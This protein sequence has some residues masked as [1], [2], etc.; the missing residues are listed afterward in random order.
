MEFSYK[1]NAKEMKG[2]H[3]NSKINKVTV[4]FMKIIKIA[5]TYVHENC[6]VTSKVYLSAD[7]KIRT[8]AHTH[9]HACMHTHMHACMHTHMH[10]CMHTQHTHIC[11]Y[12]LACTYMQRNTGMHISTTHTYTHNG[13]K[14]YPNILN[15]YY[16][17]LSTILLLFIFYCN[18]INYYLFLISILISTIYQ[19]FYYLFIFKL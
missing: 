18:I 5:I 15:M 3:S 17:Y 12:I 2:K 10:A 14:K 19:L 4:T 11:M 13:L 9:M 7:K 1:T 6:T 8:H 16:R